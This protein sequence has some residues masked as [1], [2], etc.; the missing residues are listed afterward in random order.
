MRRNRSMSS[1][2]GPVPSITFSRP[3]RTAIRVVALSA[4]MMSS[5]EWPASGT[6]VNLARLP[7][8]RVVS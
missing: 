2:L 1:Q 3:R 5:T 8:A 4:S 7:S 6:S